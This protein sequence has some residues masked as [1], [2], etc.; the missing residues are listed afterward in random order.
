MVITAVDSC[1]CNS[2]LCI[3][4][5]VVQNLYCVLEM[6]SEQEECSC[7]LKPSS[8]QKGIGI[9]ERGDLPSLFLEVIR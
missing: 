2:E 8:T 6:I 1:D 5:L 7:I 9:F 3:A 4:E